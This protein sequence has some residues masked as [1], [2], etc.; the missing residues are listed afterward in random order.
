MYVVPAAGATTGPGQD[1]VVNFNPPHFHLLVWPFAY[2]D[3]LPSLLLWQVVS[4]LAGCLCAWI[5]VRTLNLKWSTVPGMLAI[6]P[7]AELRGPL[8][9]DVVGQISLFL[10]V[11]VTLAW[12]AAHRWQWQQ[13]AAWLG[14]ATSI[15]PFFLIVVPYLLLKRQWMAVLV[16]GVTWAA[17]F[18]LG[19]AVFGPDALE[20]WLAAARWPNWQYHFQN[21]SFHAYVARVMYEWPGSIVAS[22]GAVLGTLATIWLA[23][24]RDAD[25]AWALLMT[26]ALVWAPLGW[27]YYEWILMPPVAALI[28][29]KRL[30]W[31]AWL[32]ALS[33][34]RPIRGYPVEL[35][36]TFID[37]QFRSIDFWGL[38][39]L[40][41]LLGSSEVARKP[42][43]LT[44]PA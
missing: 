20:H 19:I 31:V 10:A 6:C 9:H 21:A 39:G 7:P 13:A 3:L 24:K 26:G 4:V 2:L 36:G 29:Q 23:Y 30:P 22:L 18:G 27:V 37:Q 41:F 35:T 43:G 5:V 32:L 12:R 28:A 38:L 42:A 11:P 25:L 17:S 15:K 34:V 16:G 8:E 44:S 14:I 1:L 40:L 33:F